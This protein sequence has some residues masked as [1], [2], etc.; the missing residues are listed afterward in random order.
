MSENQKVS[1]WGIVVL[2][3]MNKKKL[4][5]LSILSLIV[6]YT[7]VFFLA[8]KQYEATATIIPL[9]ESTMS[10]LS[11]LLNNVSSVLPM[12]LGSINKETDMN[13]YLTILY[14]RTSIENLIDRYNL[15]KLY[16]IKRH[17]DAIKI[18]RKM[19]VTK[20]TMENA[21]T[22]TVR[23]KSPL[24]AADMANYLVKYLNEKIL[25]LN[26]SKS[27]DN[28]LFLEKRYDEIVNNLRDAED[29]LKIY[30]IKSGVFEAE[31]Q[32]KSS[33]EAYARMDADVAAKQ[34]EIQVLN[35]MY[36]ENSP[37]VRSAEISLRELKSKI[38]KLK[39]TSDSGSVLLSLNSLPQK[40]L[41]YYRY[42]RNVRIYTEMLSYVMPMYE[43]A[44]FDEQKNVPILQIIDNAIPPERKA[45][46]SRTS[47]SVI[48][49]C[50][51]MFVIISF[52]ILKEILQKTDNEKLL[53]LKRELFNFK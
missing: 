43:Q 40:T 33:L 49:T 23:T 29:S 51:T 44:K 2:I 21:F 41:N 17:D 46:P 53:F 39:T 12:G 36:G 10:G 31:N 27:K 30:Q 48:I 13:L 24:L 32:A 14:S 11:S 9:N 16:K 5:F 6:S 3:V 15:Q 7:A 38:N 4:I 52:I 18:V 45:F 50:I 20:I 25:E 1:L 28:R 26:V 34:V 47:M 37:N 22:I 19:F 35:K 42:Y 8:E